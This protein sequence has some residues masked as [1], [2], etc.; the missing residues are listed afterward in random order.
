MPEESEE[1]MRLISSWALD[2]DDEK[3]DKI[4]MTDYHEVEKLTN[5]L[6]IKW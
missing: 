2:Q 1:L 4:V 5:A 6:A 3:R